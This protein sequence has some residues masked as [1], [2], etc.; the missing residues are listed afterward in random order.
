[1]AL[2]F[3]IVSVFAGGV[4]TGYMTFQASI[5]PTWKIIP[6]SSLRIRVVLF[7]KTGHSWLLNGD[8]PHEI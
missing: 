3:K 1:M 8:T 5:A 7:F 6:V 4:Y 2:G